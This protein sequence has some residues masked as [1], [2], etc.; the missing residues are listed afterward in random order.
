MTGTGTGAGPDRI[1]AKLGGEVSGHVEIDPG[2]GLD[3][4]AH[5]KPSPCWRRGVRL[6]SRELGMYG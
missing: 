1:N 6:G 4:A 5:I 3:F 2:E